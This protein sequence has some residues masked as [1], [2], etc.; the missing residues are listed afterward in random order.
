MKRGRR[1]LTHQTVAGLLWTA[2][3]KGAYGVLQLVVVAILARHVSPS[4]FGV[5]SA[6]IGVIALSGIVSQLGMGP[7]L[8]QRPELERRH[9]DTAFT[10]SVI[11]DLMLGAA[12]WLAAPLASSFFRIANVE[13]VLRA[14]AWVFPLQGLATVAESL[15]KREL[16]FRSLANLDVVSYGIGYGVVGIALALLGKGVWALVVAQIAQNVVKTAILLWWQPPRLLSVPDR[17]A[18]RQLMGFGAGFTVAKIANQ[19]AAQSDYFV[20]GRYLG[21]A[22]LGYYGRAYNLMSAPASGFGTILDAVLFPAMARVQTD[23]QRLAA[24]YRRGIALIALLFLPASVALVLL[25]PEVV[26]VLLGPHWEPVVA[27]L[28]VFAAGM[29]FRTS[30]KISDSLTRA[31]GAVYR[32]AWRQILYA[33]LVIGGSWIGQH[34]GITAVAW[35]VLIAITLN[36]LLMAHLSLVDSQMSWS[37]MW[38]AHVPA[39]LVT[40]LA[41]PVTWGAATLLR[42]VAMPPLVVLIVGGAGMFGGALLLVLVAP[43]TFLGAD[44]RWM[45]ET[46]R[47]FARKVFHPSAQPTGTPA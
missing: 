45:V 40:A 23:A 31:T 6:A 10:A 22:A 12:I 34:W 42:H 26:T 20:V 19:V 13:P 11:M 30:S 25:A 46:M 24:A 7:A 5:V 4:D 29:L 47:S 32:R 33:A 36:F 44:G 15:M 27:P 37:E 16:R 17:N 3:G 38:K 18:F 35:G 1:S 8:V 2:F 39:L 21:P 14:L 41:A 43:A 28:Q 9:I